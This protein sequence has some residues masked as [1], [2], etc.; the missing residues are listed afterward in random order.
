[1][2]LD[3]IVENLAFG[4]SKVKI[5]SCLG[6]YLGPETIYIADTHLAGD[7]TVVDQLVRVPVPPAAGPSKPGAGPATATLTTDFLSDNG[8]LAAAIRQAMAQSRWSTKAVMV[9]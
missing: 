7:K 1:M 2:E 8:A 5:T 6:M 3:D 4:K 9:R